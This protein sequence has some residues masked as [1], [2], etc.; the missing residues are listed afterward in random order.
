MAAP[1]L[2][3]D[4]LRG[5][6]VALSAHYV[7]GPLAAYLLR[8]LGAEV[9]KIEPPFHDHLRHH[10]PVFDSPQ[11][12]MGAAFRA[13]N[14][15][16]QSLILDYKA[17]DAADVLGRL[18]ATCDVLID[19][20]RPG[21]LAQLL[22][23]SPETRFPKLVYLPISAYG[24]VGPLAQQ[25]GHD[26]NTLAL[27]GSLSYTAA[28]A[29]G[30]P[31]LFSAPVA[32]ILAAHTTALCACAALLGRTHD[33]SDAR[34]PRKVDASMFHAAAFLNQMQVATMN[35]FA[36]PP[37]PGQAWMNGHMPNYRIYHTADRQAIF[38][39]PIEPPL[40]AN[41]CRRVGRMELI[42]LLR[43]DPA[44]C[45]TALAALFASQSRSDWEVQ[46]ADCDCCF[47]PVLDLAAAQSHPQ[48]EALGLHPHLEDPRLGSMRLSTFPAGFGPDSAAPLL[49][50]S[51]PYPG[52]HTQ[53]VLAGL[54][55]VSAEDIARWL[56][57]GTVR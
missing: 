16:F 12:P 23:A 36:T 33:A 41:F 22:G 11:G 10:P 32:D 13:L 1:P 14:A 27:S 46:L 18:L 25:A 17:P 44:A 28:S 42:G 53:A 7:P 2:P 6:R 3:I 48:A 45:A 51:A 39:G 15:G 57:S 56:A 52:E 26:G 31:A 55:G 29:E 9:I 43:D 54:P 35:L 5:V 21:Q 4:W 34:A 30:G 47:T 49:P 50:S 20:H 24:Q 19:G 38:F 8:C 40:F 37:R